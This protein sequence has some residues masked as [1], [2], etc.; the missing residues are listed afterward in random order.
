MSLDDLITGNYINKLIKVA[1]TAKALKNAPSIRGWVDDS[2]QT[3]ALW[4]ALD[5]LEE[6]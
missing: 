6:E 2:E 4:D 5:E 3:L 1:E